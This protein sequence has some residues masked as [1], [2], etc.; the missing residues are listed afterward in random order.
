MSVDLSD[1]VWYGEEQSE[2]VM[3]T[4]TRVIEAH[5]SFRKQSGAVRVGSAGSAARA[6]VPAF[7]PQAFSV[8]SNP[9]VMMMY[10]LVAGVWVG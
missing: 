2:E 7:D 4:T 9:P 5:S 6:A 8:A 3:E 1:G 10:V